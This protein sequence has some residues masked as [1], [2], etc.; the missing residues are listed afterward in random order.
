MGKKEEKEKHSSESSLSQNNKQE[1]RNH[2]KKEKRLLNQK[3]SSGM[4]KTNTYR[5]RLEEHK[6]LKELKIESDDEI[7][8][9]GSGN[10][11]LLNVM[12]NSVDKKKYKNRYDDMVRQLES[13]TESESSISYFKMRQKMTHY[14]V[15]I[16]FYQQKDN[17]G[18]EHTVP[19][20]LPL[21]NITTTK[22]TKFFPVYRKWQELTQK[23][24]KKQQLKE[25]DEDEEIGTIKEENIYQVIREVPVVQVHGTV[26]VKKKNN[27]G[28]VV[29]EIHDAGFEY[30]E[31]YGDDLPNIG[32]VYDDYYWE[33]CSPISG[34][35]RKGDLNDEQQFE[36]LWSGARIVKLQED[37]TFPIR[38]VRQRQ[39]S[40]KMSSTKDSQFLL[41]LCAKY[42]IYC[43]IMAG[44]RKRN[45]KL[46]YDL[47]S[48]SKPEVV[49]AIESKKKR[50]K[51]FLKSIMQ[52]INT[53]DKFATVINLN[54]HIMNE[55]CKK[56]EE[57]ERQVKI[58]LKQLT[59]VEEDLLNKIDMTQKN[60]GKKLDKKVLTHLFRV[61]LKKIIQL[62]EI[63]S[64][65]LREL[66]KLQHSKFNREIAMGKK[67]DLDNFHEL[68]KKKKDL[69]KLCIK[70]TTLVDGMLKDQNKK[71]KIFASFEEKEKLIESNQ[72][73]TLDEVSDP[74]ERVRLKLA[75]KKKRSIRREAESQAISKRKS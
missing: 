73:V 58:R 65:Y 37:K 24:K 21:E 43:K 23:E 33:E 68:S 42:L 50:R 27:K 10:K 67:L 60:D 35:Q 56:F 29:E 13:K 6:K 45:E 74:D 30:A 4:E 53:R 52:Y 2:Q 70:S 39:H 1:K 54:A 5:N 40:V 3:K 47:I 63:H 11:V 34:E 36:F 62:K 18:K 69:E 20:R 57:A 12:K 51:S 75:L 16:Y 64:N 28:I 48:T 46:I 15:V 41:E 17:R 32:G 19:I 71:K 31:E 44:L 14:P 8:K 59:L 66:H 55:E 9:D 7:V 38:K 61:K 22:V 72:A 26:R 25:T 49:E